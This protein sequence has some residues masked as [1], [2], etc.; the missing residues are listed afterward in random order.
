[1][2]KIFFLQCSLYMTLVENNF[3]ALLSSSQGLH[4]ARKALS[5]LLIKSSP[6]PCLPFPPPLPPS[7]PFPLL[8]P[9]ARLALHVQNHSVA[10]G[11]SLIAFPSNKL[12]SSYH[13]LWIHGPNVRNL[14]MESLF[15]QFIYFI[16]LVNEL[17]KQGPW[18]CFH[19]SYLND[20]KKSGPL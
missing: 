14:F 5:R 12:K 2:E 9:G 13:L 19:V 11:R 17:R 18:G 16:F 1:M 4:P 6:L 10:T 7:S 20:H 3:R 15:A 8:P